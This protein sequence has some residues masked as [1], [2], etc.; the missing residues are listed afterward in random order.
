[1]A[2]TGQSAAATAEVGPPS[3]A[4][5]HA[6]LGKSTSAWPQIM[7]GLEEQFGPVALEWRPSDLAFGRLCLVRCDGQTLLYL[8]PMAGQLLVGV[9]LGEGAYRRAVASELRQGIKQMLA[10]AKPTAE[11]RGIRFTVKTEADIAEVVTLT[12]CIKEGD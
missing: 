9:V 6:A 2:A 11:G 5:L 1:M 10:E 4:E 3:A 7:S 8:I 12:R